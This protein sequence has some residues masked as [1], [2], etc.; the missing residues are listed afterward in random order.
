[1]LAAERR[2]ASRHEADDPVGRYLARRVGLTS[3]PSCLR[4][5]FNAR[6]QSDRP[7]F[8]PAMI[9][10]VTRPDGAPS[11]LHR[12]YL[13]ADGRKASVDAPRRLM[14]GTVAKG[15]ANCSN[16]L[17]C[18][19]FIRKGKV[20][21]SGLRNIV[22]TTRF[23]AAIL[24]YINAMQRACDQIFFEFAGKLHVEQTFSSANHLQQIVPRPFVHIDR[25]HTSRKVPIVNE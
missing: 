8:H 3:F 13:T 24:H 20:F 2:L 16:Q 4:T 11:V 10:M 18:V 9:A 21:V 7:S 1:V 23:V 14:P 25:N 6:Y 15:A 5:A 17:L 22:F 12:T 19:Q